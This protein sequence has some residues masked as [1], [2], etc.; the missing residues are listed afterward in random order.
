MLLKMEK[1]RKARVARA[2]LSFF[3]SFSLYSSVSMDEFTNRIYKKTIG[4]ACPFNLCK[5]KLQELI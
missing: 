2:L 3:F 1:K 4:E 5:D